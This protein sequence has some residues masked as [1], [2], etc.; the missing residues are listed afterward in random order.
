[1]NSGFALSA[2]HADA[3]VAFED[4]ANHAFTE[5]AVLYAD[6][7]VDLLPFPLFMAHLNDVVAGVNPPT[8]GPMPRGKAGECQY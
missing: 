6:G 5:V 2:L 8:A 4:P 1:M 7:H 3:I